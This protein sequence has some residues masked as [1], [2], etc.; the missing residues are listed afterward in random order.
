MWD[1]PFYGFRWPDHSSTLRQA[2]GNECGLDIQQNGPCRME[3]TCRP[4]NYFTCPVVQGR[5]VL[6]EAAGHLIEFDS[7]QGCL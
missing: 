5:R 3:F 4:V 1:C 6:L 2:G 7:G